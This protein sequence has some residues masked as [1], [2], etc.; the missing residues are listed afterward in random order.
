VSPTRALRFGDRVYARQGPG[1]FGLQEFNVG[2]PQAVAAGKATIRMTV[3]Y[4]G[5]GVAKG[6]TAT[7]LINGDL[8]TK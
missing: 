6:G 2:A 5:G 8:M 7:I 4:D 3:D 1:R